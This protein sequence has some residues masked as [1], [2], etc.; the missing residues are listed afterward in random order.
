MILV[1]AGPLIALLDRSDVHHQRCMDVLAQLA[2]Q[3]LV[4]TW[5]CLTEAMHLLGRQG[6]YPLQRALWSTCLD[7]TVLLHDLT[8]AE[9]R[10]AAAWM[11]QYQDLPMDLGDATLMAVAVALDLDTI[12]TLDSDFRIYRMRDGSALTLIP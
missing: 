10:D 8:E 11:D 4:T 3:D 6:G 2:N 7:G 12:F 1:D 5:A 9:A